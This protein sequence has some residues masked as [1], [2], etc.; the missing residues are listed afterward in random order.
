MFHFKANKVSAVPWKNTHLRTYLDMYLGDRQLAFSAQP[1]I[2]VT[3]S[4][5]VFLKM[6]H[7]VEVTYY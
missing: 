2:Y 4:S 5:Q 1:M 7:A 6:I 3:N